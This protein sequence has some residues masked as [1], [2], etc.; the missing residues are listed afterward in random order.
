MEK[1]KSDDGGGGTH[2]IEYESLAATCHGRKTILEPL[3]RGAYGEVCVSRRDTRLAVKFFKETWCWAYEVSMLHYL[4][5]RGAS[6]LA[7]RVH[8]INPKATTISMRRMDG[9]LADV[10]F[11]DDPKKKL[12]V[13][14]DIIRA[15]LTWLSLGVAHRDIKPQN[16]LVTKEGDLAFCD[17]GMAVPLS[18]GG[19]IGKPGCRTRGNATQTRMVTRWYR[20]PEILLDQR[21]YDMERVD[22]WALGCILLELWTCPNTKPLRE[23]PH[24]N[25]LAGTSDLHQ[26]LLICE[27]LGEP[28]IE[29][30]CSGDIAHE[31][32]LRVMP[33]YYTPHH[34]ARAKL[35]KLME[36]QLEGLADWESAALKS[37]IHGCLRVDPSARTV[38]ADLWDNPLL[39]DGGACPV[40]QPSPI[41]PIA[42][43]RSQTAICSFHTALLP[44]FFPTLF[45][46]LVAVATHVFPMSPFTVLHA[47]A[48][49]VTYLRRTTIKMERGNLQL[50]GAACLFV[51][52]SVFKEADA[53]CSYHSLVRLCD[54]AY[55][56][57]QVADMVTSVCGHVPDLHAIASSASLHIYLRG[58]LPIDLSWCKMTC[59][60][61]LVGGFRGPPYTGHL[62][63]LI[64]E[65]DSEVDRRDEEQTRFI[66]DCKALLRREFRA[67]EDHD[68]IQTVFCVSP[69]HKEVCKKILSRTP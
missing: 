38:A 19:P 67:T 44:K 3:G 18:R 13:S 46:W 42:A 4:H 30:L 21:N 17:W 63:R 59:Y 54:G 6:H 40:K 11:N 24:T 25:L 29:G 32:L 41:W 9:T 34:F 51:A 60:A 16:I 65:L 26:L 49:T 35:D 55:T 61:L 53:G 36:P 45:R 5:T 68:V 48:F 22:I 23:R 47:L 14:V 50:L 39:I 1:K 7:P 12:R 58:K 43:S 52:M 27:V 57:T 66:R 31:E 64:P 69:E 10:N 56:R 15:V 28:D 33:R 62:A 20:A 37:L 2:T 8:G